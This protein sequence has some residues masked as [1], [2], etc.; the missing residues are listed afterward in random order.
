MNK[1]FFILPLLAAVLIFAF[2]GCQEKKYSPT[3]GETKGAA[4]ES[5]FRFTEKAKDEFVNTY[6]QTKVDLKMASAREGIP[7]LLEGKI[8]FYICGRG[9]NEDELAFIR[10]ANKKDEI[11]QY[12]FCYDGIVLTVQKSDTKENISINELKKMLTG[13]DRSYKIFMPPFKS[14]T[15]E[16][17][18][19]LLLDGKDPQNV[20]LMESEK[21]VLDAVKKT[22]KSMG[23]VGLNVIADSSAYK[24]LKVCSDETTPG[25]PEY[26]EPHMGFFV[27]GSYPLSKP[28]YIFTNEIVTGVA[29]GFA[30]FLTGNEGQ[31]VVFKEKLGPLHA[32]LKQK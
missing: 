32:I 15:Y 22:A 4:D 28:C 16:Y 8:Q 1:K 13:A 21:D 26:F 27:N 25:G 14:S 23:L 29:G 9:F 3:K 5:L 17:I 18:K 20:K 2:N 24:F 12:K 19:L 7:E 30:T 11:S 6:T 10:K 31:K